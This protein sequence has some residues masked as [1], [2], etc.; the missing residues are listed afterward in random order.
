M[1]FSGNHAS[2]NTEVFLFAAVLSVRAA[3]KVFQSIEGMLDI[4]ISLSTF[5]EGRAG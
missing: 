1:L 4:S 3:T 2:V 5:V